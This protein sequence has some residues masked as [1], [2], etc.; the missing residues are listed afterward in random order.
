MMDFF[1]FFSTGAGV[2]G[3][4]Q[5]V[6]GQ[7][8]KLKSAS[9]FIDSPIVIEEIIIGHTTACWILLKKKELNPL[10]CE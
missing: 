9:Q 8:G 1:F 6:V 7:N 3:S 2:G 4:I 10:F 5:L